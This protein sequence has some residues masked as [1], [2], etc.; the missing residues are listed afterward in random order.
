MPPLTDHR[1]LISSRTHA[2]FVRCRTH[3]E[4][5]ATLLAC[6]VDPTVSIVFRQSAVMEHSEL[7]WILGCVTPMGWLNRMTQFKDKSASGGA[8]NAGLGLYS[9]PVLQAADILLYK[10][11][12]VPV[13]DDQRQHLELARDIATSFNTRFGAGLL[14][15]PEAI[16]PDGQVNRVMSLRDGTKKMSK[17]DVSDLSRINLVDDADAIRKKINKA[18]TDAIEGITFDTEARPGVA[19]LLAI[20]AAL[21]SRTPAEVAADF[22]TAQTSAL[23]RSLIELL[24]E[25]VCPIG[26]EIARLLQEADYLDE[27]SG[28]SAMRGRVLDARL[29]AHLR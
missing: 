19:N 5:A 18:T 24:V 20:H 21:E 11:T 6:G 16:V 7:A 27:V 10:A 14:P 4:V 26:E 23:K 13:G 3:R 25:R 8:S 12:A 17:S 9:Y 2:V 1:R 15:L 28:R 29:P 22:E